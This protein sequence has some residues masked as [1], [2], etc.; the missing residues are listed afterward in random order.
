MQK[1][2]IF[3]NANEFEVEKDINE[4]AKNHKILQISLGV[5]K[6]DGYGSVLF[7]MVLYEENNYVRL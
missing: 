3:K 5:R 6:S 4:F 1:V 7:C 2:K